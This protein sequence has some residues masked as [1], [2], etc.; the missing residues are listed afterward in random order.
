VFIRSLIVSFLVFAPFAALSAAQTTKPED[1][2]NVTLTV[3]QQNHA[4]IREMRRVT[5]SDGR[6]RLAVIGVP[7]ALMPE[8][9]LANGTTEGR[10]RVL[11]QVYESALLTPEAL[12]QASVGGTVQIIT[13]NPESG[14]ETFAP[15]EVLRAQGR[16]ALLRLDGRIRTFDVRRIA[17]DSAPSNLRARPTLVLDLENSEAGAETLNLSYLTRGLN[18]RADYVARLTED[19]TEIQLA[20]WVTLTNSTGTEFKNARLRVIA[21][22]VNRTMQTRRYA[23]PQALMAS[24]EKARGLPAESAVSDLRV[25]DFAERITIGGVESRQLALL[26]ATPVK[27]EKAYILSAH[28]SH[29]RSIRR[30]ILRTN[31]AVRYRFKNTKAAGLGRSLP[32]GT[33]RLYAPTEGGDIFRGEDRI[34]HTPKGEMITVTAG[35]ATDITSERKQTEF[36]RNG[37]PKNVFESA[38][39]ITLRNAKAEAVTVIVIERIPGDWSML[40]ES[41]VHTKRSANEALWRVTVPSGGEAALTYRVRTQF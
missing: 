8:T 29:F 6:S 28:A 41:Q 24:A 9:V 21:G 12:L 38:H 16:E 13:T 22:T 7:S 35:L 30:G 19:E 32:A 39:S 14:A 15:A 27:I 18:W 20:G 40:S 37:L 3:Y 17:F 1:Q 34:R 4:L 33:V 36:R 31:P 26:S 23:Q 5:L 2:T 25:F 10:L 11:G